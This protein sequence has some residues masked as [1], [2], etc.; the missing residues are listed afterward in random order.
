V[1]AVIAFVFGALSPSAAVAAFPGSNGRIAYTAQT[2]VLP[3]G[4]L[5][6]DIFTVLP[7]G[8][9][10]QQL[11]DDSAGDEEPSWAADG[12]RLVFTR[13]FPGVRN[14]Q[15][16]TM[17]ADGVDLVRVIDTGHPFPSASPSFSPNGRRIL[18]T[19]GARS[20]QFAPTAPTPAG[21]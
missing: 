21:Y 3:S 9:G 5:K 10:V 8:S 12:R 15:I 14:V 13:G 4:G 1:V 18:Y 16:F 20:E 7:D 19:N 17:S 2:G 11:T 6:T